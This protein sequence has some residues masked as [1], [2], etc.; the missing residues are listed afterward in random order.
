MLVGLGTKWGQPYIGIIIPCLLGKQR[1]FETT[2]SI[3]EYTYVR[4][5]NASVCWSNTHH[6]MV[7]SK[8]YR[9]FS[10]WI[11]L[12]M[13]R[14]VPLYHYHF[15]CLTSH[16]RWFCP[17]LIWTT[18]IFCCFYLVL[19]PHFPD[20]RSSSWTKSSYCFSSFLQSSC[21][22]IF[23]GDGNNETV[24]FPSEKP[25]DVGESN[26]LQPF[27]VVLQFY[28]WVL[29]INSFWSKRYPSW[30]RI[31]KSQPQ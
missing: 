9:H 22:W 23:D 13:F 31:M 2:S 24:I 21:C 17:V 30:F 3:F 25:V 19:F 12:I 14:Y 16:V 28:P 26:H 4:W 29:S 18:R 6:V 8:S 20:S 7:I 1:I 5:L 27:I 15:C 11:I 10:R